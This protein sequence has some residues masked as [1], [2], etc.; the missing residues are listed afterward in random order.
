MKTLIRLFVI[1]IFV[2]VIASCSN[3]DSSP[4]PGPSITTFNATLDGASEVPGNN[5]TAT[6]TALLS[7][8]NTTK[9]FSITVTHTIA[10][11]TGGH[12]HMGAVGVNGNVVFPFTNLVSPIS[13]TSPALTA[14]QEAD[15]KANLYYVNIHT[16]AFQTGE[17]RGQLIKGTTSGSGGGG[18]Y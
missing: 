8:N 13:F 16:A 9:T 6:G 5:S 14:A 12:I 18:G 1:L 3:N 7:F 17:I 11:P 4:S 10:S 15:L 2:S